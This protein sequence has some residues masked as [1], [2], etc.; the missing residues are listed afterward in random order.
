[1]TVTGWVLGAGAGAFVLGAGVGWG[2][3][4]DVTASMQDST[5]PSAVLASENF[6]APPDSVDR[7]PDPAW[8][9]PP[10]NPEPWTFTAW[11]GPNSAE[12]QGVGTIVTVSFDQDIPTA[13]RWKVADS[14]SVTSTSDE[15]DVS[16][17]WVWLDGK[18]VAWRP[19]G[20][21]LPHQEVTVKSDWAKGEPLLLIATK[22]GKKKVG[23]D[24]YY[25][26]IFDSKIRLKVK[27]GYDQRFTVDADTFEGEV[28]RDGKVVR[29][30]PVSLGKAGW[31]TYGGVKTFME[32]YE[33]KR[34]YNPGQWDVTVPYALRLTLSGEFLH[35]APWNSSIGSANLSHG[36]TNVTVED[37]RWF[38][39]NIQRGD[40]VVTE[41]GKGVPPAWDGAGA[42]WNIS[43]TA[44]KA[45]AAE[46]P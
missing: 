21:W 37:A 4:P 22:R 30:V 18:T 40:P 6:V 19:K 14:L 25:S 46:T 5:G 17:P 16:A 31:E 2:A 35:S 8:A 1:M 13:A 32:R 43:W 27:I 9:P 38:Y 34:L 42:G 10:P 11:A 24:D 15:Q 12:E 39:K 20:F 33:E 29:E 36:C 45:M 26:I 41:N 44:W 28:T 3:A 7:F 23:V